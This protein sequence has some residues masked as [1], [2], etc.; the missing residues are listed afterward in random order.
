MRR[1]I[2]HWKAYSMAS[3]EMLARSHNSMAPWTLVLANDKRQARLNIKDLLG[4]L[5]YTG[6]DKR[7]IRPGPQI[8]FAY[9]VS[10]LENGEL[11]K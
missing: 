2:K 1:S 4:R 3:N 9:D 5:H 7:L 11:A 6:K 8:V 10:N